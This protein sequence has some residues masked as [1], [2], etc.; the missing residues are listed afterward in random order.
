MEMEKKINVKMLEL[1]IENKELK[2]R[3]VE[4][5]TLQKECHDL[6]KK[7]EAWNDENHAY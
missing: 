5:T 6:K 4:W 3:M 1:T 7:E 2:Q